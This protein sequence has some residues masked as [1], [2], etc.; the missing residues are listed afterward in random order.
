MV[1]PDLVV[2]AQNVMLA[3][4]TSQG[5][6]SSNEPMHGI[7]GL[8]MGYHGIETARAALTGLTED[9]SQPEPQEPTG[10]NKRN[11]SHRLYPGTFLFD[12]AKGTPGKN[13]KEAPISKLAPDL[14]LRLSDCWA[15]QDTEGCGDRDFLLAGCSAEWTHGDL[16]ISWQ[17][18]WGDFLT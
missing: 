1:S 9:L 7:K 4:T 10:S 13:H 16:P 5:S 2:M 3:K 18:C 15:T 12:G 6:A 17:E 8:T 14:T 11:P